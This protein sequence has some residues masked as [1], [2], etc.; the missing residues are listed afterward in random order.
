LFRWQQPLIT[1][2]AQVNWVQNIEARKVL[3]QAGT[4]KTF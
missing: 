3:V 2:M 1:L 4:G